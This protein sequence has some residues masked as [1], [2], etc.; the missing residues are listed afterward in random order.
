MK[1]ISK[2][3][4]GTTCLTIFSGTAYLSAI[5]LAPPPNY[6]VSNSERIKSYDRLAVNNAYEKKTR[7]QEF[8]LGLSRWRRKLIKEEGV[9]RGRVLEIGAGCGGNVVY[10]PSQYF[11]DN[12]EIQKYMAELMHATKSEEAAD[13]RKAE[14]NAG[15]SNVSLI[16]DRIKRL[17]QC[18]EIVL[19]DRSAN[20]I[21]SCSQKLQSRLGYVPYRYPDYNLDG[22]RAYIKGRQKSSKEE[23]AG[24]GSVRRRKI[25][26]EDGSYK[27]IMTMPVDTSGENEF[28]ESENSTLAP[29]LQEIVPGDKL[30]L[31]SKADKKELTAREMHISARQAFRLAFE[32]GLELKETSLIGRRGSRLG[33]VPFGNAVGKH[34]QHPKEGQTSAVLPAVP[35][36]L[37]GES[38]DIAPQPLFSVANYAAEQLP[39]AD[40][41][42]DTVVDMFGLCSYDDP[43]RALREM[44][45]VCKPGGKLLLV[46]HGRGHAPRVNNH[47]DKWAPRHAKNWGCWWNRDIRRTVR[48]SGLTVEK[49][50][51]KHFGTSHYII[52]KP[53]K[54]MDEWDQYHASHPTAH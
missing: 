25:V 3:I 1:L 14:H 21:E 15:M 53:Y 51:S 19:C 13:P 43:V 8:Y 16:L 45:R 34:E 7:S 49:W 44:S 37:R 28:A 17:S 38:G 11:T 2:V 39:F 30:P 29:I 50:E 42:F 20:M 24:S 12:N 5:T 6:T 31:L 26:Q 32:R 18:D 35:P 40:N 41:S 9:L 52:A 54:T 22:I 33:D 48:L 47:L 36:A 27:E 46:E 10:Y 23:P 4:V